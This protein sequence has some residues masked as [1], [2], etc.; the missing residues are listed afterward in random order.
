[1]GS[2][3]SKPQATFPQPRGK[4]FRCS[5][6][7]LLRS[8]GRSIFRGLEPLP[9]LLSTRRQ[10]LLLGLGRQLLFD[11]E[12]EPLVLAELRRRVD[13]VLGRVVAVEDLVGLAAAGALGDLHRRVALAPG[14]HLEVVVVAEGGLAGPGVDLAHSWAPVAAGWGRAGMVMLQSTPPMWPARTVPLKRTASMK[15][16][17]ASA[18]I[19]TPR[20]RFT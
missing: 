8:S 9:D 4:S 19:P 20:L 5:C 13:Q 14:D 12:L 16:S 7:S 6:W 15:I 2:S 11:L 1:M 10:A 3:R 18:I 17:T